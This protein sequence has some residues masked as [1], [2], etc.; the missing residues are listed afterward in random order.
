MLAD[1]IVRRWQDYQPLN[2]LESIYVRE[3]LPLAK[4]TLSHGTS[5]SR[6]SRSISWKRCFAMLSRRHICASTRP[7][8]WFGQRALQKWPFLRHGRAGEARSLPIL[9]HHDSA[10][11]MSF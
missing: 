11:S 1:T 10:P 7:A 8:S 9:A 5:C 6:R 4:S 3:G 2:R